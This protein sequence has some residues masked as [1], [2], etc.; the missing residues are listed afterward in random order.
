VAVVG[1]ASIR[2]RPDLTEFRKELKA[3]LN[4]INADLTVNVKADTGKA[5]AEIQRMIAEFDGKNITVKADIDEK[6][7]KAAETRIRNVFSEISKVGGQLGSTTLGVSKFAIAAGAAASATVGLTNVVGGLGTAIAAMGAAGVATGIAGLIALAS[8]EGTVKLATS[9]MG[10]AFKAVA[11]GDAA[12]LSEAL[13]KLSPNAQDFV[14]HVSALKPLLD[15]L[16]LDVQQNLFRGLGVEVEKTGRALQ[17]VASHMFI[18]LARTMNSAGKDILQFVRDASTINALENIATDVNAG[19]KSAVSEGLRPFFSALLDISGA[20]AKL[21]PKMGEGLG[22]L[23]KEFGDFINKAAA[24]GQ[25]DK[26][27]QEGID[28]AKQFGRIIR[29]FGVAI[30]NVFHIAAGSTGGFL[31]NLEKAAKA[32]RAFTESADGR[33]VL[34]QVFDLI[35]NLSGSFGVFLGALRPLLPIIGKFADVLGGE[36]GKILEALG[37]IIEDVADVL[38]DTLV[39]ILPDLTPIVILLAKAFADIVKAAVPLIPP[40]VKILQ[41]LTP[42][43]DPIA[44]LISAL[45]PPLAKIL[46]ALAPIIKILADVLAILILAFVKLVDAIVNLPSLLGD[47]PGTVQK[48]ISLITGEMAKAAV[49][50]APS[51]VQDF[52]VA[53]NTALAGMQVPQAAEAGKNLVVSIVQ[54]IFGNS[55][56]ITS[57]VKSV[58]QAILDLFNGGKNG[59]AEAGADISRALASGMTLEQQK[60]FDAAKAIAEKIFG[61][62]NGAKPSYEEAGRGITNSLTSGVSSQAPNLS[63][64][65]DRI[66]DSIH[67]GFGGVSLRSVGASI[68]QSLGFGV[69]SQVSWLQGIFNS[70]TNQ[71][72]KW[73][74]PITRDRKLLVPAGE[75]IMDGFIGAILSRQ[76]ELRRGLQGVTALVEDT[77]DPGS[78]SGISAAVDAA[79]GASVT[80]STQLEQAP[81]HVNITTDEERLKGFVQVEISEGNREVRRKVVGGVNP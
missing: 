22:R 64:E 11:E 42:L 26:F 45:L 16:K 43:I 80:A 3:E 60:A 14:K 38:L 72:P 58:V 39:Q 67:N 46:E 12:A 56:L 50:Q 63:N 47:I 24:S 31:A 73:K 27:F 71:I 66:V 19:F 25:L 10:D 53:L 40:L 37:P 2:V 59:Y 68:V 29:D 79:V 28:K 36:L 15:Q 18:D 76:S 13:K 61:V 81:I 35:H 48:M 9:G 41:A 52:Q 5:K 20:G 70:I 4:K 77:F 17:G 6:N 51:F 34:G 65:I 1:V 57:A 44:K 74:G 32:F 30:A 75:Q 69:Q 49:G 21:L 33:K 78:R 55:D 54:G 23:G 7:L 8:I 62:F